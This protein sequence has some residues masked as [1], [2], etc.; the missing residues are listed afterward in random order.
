MVPVGGRVPAEGRLW[1]TAAY[2]G[3][4]GPAWPSSWGGGEGAAHTTSHNNCLIK[5]LPGAALSD[6]RSRNE[7]LSVKPAIPL[8]SAV[9][10]K[11]RGIPA[12]RAVESPH[13][14]V[15]LLYARAFPL[16]ASAS[17]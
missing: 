6:L 7:P 13:L 14:P 11:N 2:V 12:R 15:A 10:L 8:N 4:Q 9:V 1:G 17:S 3:L 5:K 16:A